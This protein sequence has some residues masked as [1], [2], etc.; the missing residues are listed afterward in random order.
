MWKVEYEDSEVAYNDPQDMVESKSKG[1]I[2]RVFW[3]GHTEYWIPI[4]KIRR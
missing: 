3:S 2:N 4:N 1:K